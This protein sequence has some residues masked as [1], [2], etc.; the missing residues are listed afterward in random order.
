MHP[1]SRQTQPRPPVRA[2]G[3]LRTA[4]AAAGTQLRRH[5]VLTSAALTF[6]VPALAT[7]QQLPRPVTTLGQSACPKGATWQTVPDNAPIRRCET[8]KQAG[9]MLADGRRHG[10]WTVYDVS[11]AC[12]VR[13]TVSTYHM[14]RRTG[15]ALHFV[16]AKPAPPSK[17]TKGTPPPCVEQVL[18]VGSYRDGKPHGAWLILDEQGRKREHYTV[19]TGVRHGPFSLYN[20]KG[21][22]VAAGCHQEG[23]EV[24]R[25]DFLHKDKWATPCNTERKV[26]AKPVGDGTTKVSA[27]QTKASK[28][29]MLAQQSKRVKL[30]VMYLKKAVSLAPDNTRYKKL[31]DAAVAEAAE[32]DGGAAPSP[33]ASR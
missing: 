14:G 18:K 4:V 21:V 25:Y 10:P 3:A 29:V 24:W 15:P 7:A 17:R 26:V 28:L 20:S 11:Q 19:H 22:R 31:L 30:K 27:A 12:R 2:A 8:P 1:N 5:A 16:C 32:A 13:Q 6:L 33:D 23:N 9:C